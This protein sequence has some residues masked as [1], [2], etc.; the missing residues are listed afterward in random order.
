MV[1]VILTTATG[2]ESLADDLEKKLSS[3]Q[4]YALPDVFQ[5]SSNERSKGTLF[6]QLGWDHLL[7]AIRICDLWSTIT[8]TP[9]SDPYN[10]LALSIHSYYSSISPTIPSL[11]IL[12]ARAI[13]STRELSSQPFKTIQEKDMLKQYSNL[14]ALF[15]VFLLRHI[16]NPVEGFLV[17]FHESHLSHLLSLQVILDGSNPSSIEEQIHLTIITLLENLSHDAILSDR[18][19]LFTLFLLAY[20]LRDDAR[21]TTRVSTIPPHI[22]SIQWCLRV[23][24]VREILDKAPLYDGDM[25]K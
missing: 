24:A 2:P 5:P 3:L 19:D 15:L 16:A 21:N 6:A 13:L 23:S 7:V 12:T 17:P 8:T 9:A 1:E 10:H 11:P 22:S 18:K 4:L 25:Y 14:M 20:H